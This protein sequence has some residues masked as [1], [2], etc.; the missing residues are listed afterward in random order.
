MCL[1]RLIA[2]PMT[3]SLL[4]LATSH[5]SA[6][7]EEASPTLV[8]PEL[9]API[10]APYPES[11]RSSGKSA[12][13]VLSLTLGSD[14]TVRNLAVTQSA[15]PAFD[16]AALT[17]G[18]QLR[19][20]PATRAGVAIAA[21][22][23]FTFTFS[24]PP[25]A[26]EEQA[27]D[28]GESTVPAVPISDA[29]GPPPAAPQELDVIGDRVARE[30]TRYSMTGAE[31]Q[32]IPGTN[33]DAF[34]AIESMPGVAWPP[35]NQG[36]LLVRGSG[37]DDTGVFMDGTQIPVA[38]HF[39]GVSSVVPTELVER[40][41]FFP[42][43]FGPEYGRLL[44]GV[45]DAHLRSPASDG[46]HGIAQ[47]DTLAVSLIAEGPLGEHTRFLVA[48]RRSWV[49]LWIGDFLRA[50][51][52]NQVV[53]APVYYDYQAMLEQDVGPSTKVR[54]TLFGSSDSLNIVLNAP[55]E[56]DPLSGTL[57]NS[58]SFFRL[59][60]RSDTR[61]G[62]STRWINTLSFGLD[63][64]DRSLSTN[65]SIDGQLWPLAFRSDFRTP[66]SPWATLVL[67][68]D[69]V[70]ENAH[71]TIQTPWN[72]NYLGPLYG[73]PAPY[74]KAAATI[75]QPAAYALLDVEPVPALKL[76]GS[77]RVDYQSDIDKWVLSPR[78]A[79][80]WD[81]HPGFRRTT[82]KAG[83]G[84][85]DQ[86]PRPEE[87]NPP[88]GSPELGY[89]RSIQYGLGIEQELTR[90][91]ELS[92]E[93]FYKSLSQLVVL[94]LDATGSALGANYTNSGSGRAYGGELLLR[95]KAD[96]HFFAWLSYTLAHSDRRTTPGAP[97]ALFDFDE[98]H[99][100]TALAS[101]RFSS[102]WQVGLRF[103]LASGSPYIPIAT[104]IYDSD[105]G[106][107]AP[108]NGALNS[109]RVGTSHELDVR[110][111]KKWTFPRWSLTAY[112]D[113]ENAYFHGNP[114]GLQYNYNYTQAQPATGIPFLPIIGV[115][116][117]L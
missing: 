36:F 62:D 100:L 93:G 46:F 108:L 17:A 68:I 23:P 105:A 21:R 43:N 112:V 106:A 54:L 19:F 32:E 97:Y 35:A 52:D 117:E 48:A 28:A 78:F 59:Q 81:L 104:A 11:E 89:N 53:S 76:L 107:Y 90:Q 6:R 86:P 51:G 58:N 44:G 45:V 87:A 99:N 82:L 60:L 4:A 16:E 83:I 22:I 111:E 69:A 50:G 113:V 5:R 26:P 8:A 114:V 115:R 109:A 85:Y 33:G 13:V 12:T 72:T 110:V 3:L 9:I 24:A 91:I 66:L 74:L 70:H 30:V 38:Y 18:R 88:L 75:F 29:K 67:G 84:V 37:P 116:G 64:P 96:A 15:G 73:Q 1:R 95:Y 57:T 25:A 7:A 55:P 103:R 49:D 20:R 47:I 98:T 94:N 102:G 31:I 14:G 65:L 41:D 101:Y 63:H 92:V 61:L 80:R 77:L 42:G 34:R 71:A 40:L 79:A 10:E 56:S 2:I 39:G 27:P